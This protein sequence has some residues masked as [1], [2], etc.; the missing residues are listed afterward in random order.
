LALE[1]TFL[2]GIAGAREEKG[3][4]GSTRPVEEPIS[5]ELVLVDRE[6]ARRARLA[7]PEPPWLLPVLAEPPQAEAP[8]TRP[9]RR[10]VPS[11]I[12]AI[13]TG[14][15]ALLVFVVVMALA[16]DHLSGPED[17]TFSTTPSAA[18]QPQP[19]AAGRAQAGQQTE[20]PERRARRRAERPSVNAPKA[21][22][23]TKGADSSR[24]RPVSAP[25]T[26]AARPRALAAKQRVFTW[27]RHGA[28]TYYQLYFQRGAK[29]IYK[30]RTVK[31]RLALP[32]RLKLK[33]G[34]YTV[35]V[36]PAVTTDAGIILG[37]AVL[38]KKIRV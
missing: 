14:A 4:V 13:L 20:R 6:L 2:S 23:S 24:R 21:T 1:G 22:S 27:R 11:H 12:G 35:L 28:A 8:A 30:A 19:A 38:A 29:T 5:A 17:L 15:C 9:H 31:L 37:P 36:Q 7:L 34:T 18:R 33:P 26:A 16:A 32:A 25:K 3:V 10:P